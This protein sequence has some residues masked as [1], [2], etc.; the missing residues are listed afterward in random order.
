[1]TVMFPIGGFENYVMSDS[2]TKIGERVVDLATQGWV[3]R[4]NTSKPNSIEDYTQRALADGATEVHVEST[5]YNING[6]LLSTQDPTFVGIYEKSD[7]ESTVPQRVIDEASA[8]LAMPEDAQREFL[9]GIHRDVVTEAKGDYVNR[10][11]RKY[12][13]EGISQASSTAVSLAYFA[14]KMRGIGMETEAAELETGV[15]RFLPRYF[16]SKYLL[17][18]FPFYLQ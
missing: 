12:G 6:G 18:G 1:M 16:P 9:L 11:Q 15:E 7:R 17:S 4:S 2:Y 13:W 8:Y 14:D 10:L 5:S 3:F